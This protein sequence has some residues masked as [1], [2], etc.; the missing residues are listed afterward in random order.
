MDKW[1]IYSRDGS[2]KHQSITQYNSD[3]RIV[4]QD[5]LEYTGNWMGECFLTVSIKSPYPID[6]QIG[7]YI[8]YR[9]E[10]FTLQYDPTVLKS[11]RRGAYSEGFTY[12]S[13][14][15]QS[16]SNELTQIRFHDW[17]LS[18]NLLNYTS[19]PSFS[20]YCKDVDDLADRLQAN[21]D[22]WCRANNRAKEDY[23]LFYTL[24]S[25]PSGT[26]DSSQT[27][28]TYE[29]T[30]QRA[31]DILSS[32]GIENS[33]SE[34]S[35]FLV[36]VKSQWESTY[37]TGTSYAD[38]RTDERFDRTISASSQTVWDALAFVKSQF[39]LNFIIRGRN[40]YIGTAGIPTFHLFQYGRG[41]GL[42][43]VNRTADTEQA[44]ITKL[45]A[46]GSNQNLPTRYYATL[47]TAPA[48]TVSA[49]DGKTDS[50]S[51]T[52]TTLYAIFTV[53]LAFSPN[54]FTRLYL[55]A[56]SNQAPTDQYLV[57]IRIDSY[58]VSALAS[59]I[60]SS[61]L[62]QLRVGWS[63]DS[64]SPNANNQDN[65]IGFINA[66][67]GGAVVYFSTGA[68]KSAFPSS[69]LRNTL[70][71]VLPDNMAVTSLML[72]GFPDYAL[73]DLCRCEYDETS[74]V[75]K[76]YIRTSPK[77]DFPT[78]PFYT[79][80]GKHLLS[81]S[82][83][84]YD[85]FLLSPNA[86]TLGVLEGDISCTED[87]DDNGLEAVYPTLEEVTD[88][89]AG[90]GTSGKRLDAVVIADFIDDNGV[91]P[92]DKTSNIPNFNIYLP[93]LGFDLRQA[94]EDAGGSE[95]QIS[96]KNGFC[97]GR[98]FKVTSVR[99]VDSVN[100]TVAF[101]AVLA[102]EDYFSTKF[103]RTGF[104]DDQP[105]QVS[106]LPIKAAWRLN[107][108]RVSDS[109]LDLYFPY[110]YSSSVGNVPSSMTHAYQILSG[111]NY[112]I[113]GIE[114]SDVNYVWAAAV[115]LLSKAIHY[116]CQ[117]DYTRYVYNPKID[118][119]FMARQHQDALADTTGATK[120]LHDTLKEGDLLLFSDSDL[121]LQGSV[122]IDQLH[123]RESNNNGIP[124]YDITLR[125]ET[126]VGS[127]QRLQNKVDSISTD[128]R[129]GNI[130]NSWTTPQLD[131][132][133]STLGNRYFLSKTANDTAAGI[134][135]FLNDI[136]VAGSA[137]TGGLFNTGDFT[138]RG[139]IENG[140][141]ITNSGSITTKDL[142]VTG[143]AHFFSLT[144][145]EI[146]ATG[147]AFLATPAGGF[148]ADI[149][150]PYDA[151]K[152]L[153]SSDSSDTPA[154]W[155]IYWRA[156]QN[157]KSTLNMWVK[158]DMAVCQ[159]FDV[160]EG[161]TQ[162]TANRRW[163]RLVTATSNEN[164][165]T[166]FDYTFD[167]EF[168][169]A[170]AANGAI[171]ET[172]PETG[173]EHLYHWIE[174]SNTS[175][176]DGIIQYYDPSDTP[177]AG[178]E[179]V[180]LGYWGIEKEGALTNDDD[181]RAR[182]SAIYYS[183]YSSM[184]SGLQAPFFAFYEGINH[185]A[186]LKD[187]RKSY[188][189]ANKMVVYGEVHMQSG[190]D[191]YRAAVDRG[192]YD[193][194]AT[195]NQYDR[196]SYDGSLWL[197]VSETSSSGVTPGTDETKWLRQVSKGDTGAT[198]A[199]GADGKSVYSQYSVDGDNWVSE[200][201]EGVVYKYIRTSQDGKTWSDPIKIQ[202]EDGQN[203]VSVNIT[204][205]M[206]VLGMN[207][208]P[209]EDT[210]IVIYP[211][212]W[213]G[214]EDRISDCLVWYD[215]GDA[216]DFTLLSNGS[217]RVEKLTTKNRAALRSAPN[218]V[219]KITIQYYGGTPP[220]TTTTT[221]EPTA[222]AAKA[223]IL[224]ETSDAS[225]VVEDTTTTTS[226]TTTT[227]PELL[228]TFVVYWNYSMAT[229]GL[230]IDDTYTKL[231]T[232]YV[233]SDGTVNKAEM[234]T[235]VEEDGTTVV[236]MKAN[237]IRLEGY[238]TINGGTKIDTEG[239]LI[240]KNATL[241]G[242]LRSS[243]LSDWQNDGAAG[244]YRHYVITGGAGGDDKYDSALN[245][246]VSQSS[247]GDI[248]NIIH[249]PV[250]PEYIGARVII[251]ATPFVSNTGQ[252][253]S[254]TATDGDLLGDGWTYI[255]AG[256]VFVKHAY[257]DPNSTSGPED[258]KGPYDTPTEAWGESVAWFL[259]GA[260]V[261]PSIGG[262]YYPRR[263]A[264]K[265]GAVELLGVSSMTKGTISKNTYAISASK[266]HLKDTTTATGKDSMGGQEVELTQWVVVNAQCNDIE[267]LFDA[268]G[269][270]DG[271]TTTQ[272]EEKN[273][274]AMDE[275]EAAATTTTTTSSTS[276]STSTSTTTE[277]P[278]ASAKANTAT[279]DEDD[280]SSLEQAVSDYENDNI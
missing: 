239:N 114:I 194:E 85:P 62:T 179:V 228:M 155:R 163:W 244:S 237:Q 118:D 200:L 258:G 72:P 234:G 223:N 161:T 21:T 3:G 206:G 132:L 269:S 172:D 241:N 4:Y 79:E 119:I 109:S 160:A 143:L 142:T 276:T 131:A 166:G 64:T 222:V 113:T 141:D 75:T 90:I 195:Y 129:T 170:N 93:E 184:D 266:T 252:I 70:P 219:V 130:G 63:S 232:Q 103:N 24:K 30:S 207:Y 120:S 229:S 235:L 256:K 245:L 128:I 185:F 89:Q 280:T 182:R 20:F 92:T 220:T 68:N 2:P 102:N 7:D 150:E 54:Y 81:F 1:I 44:V 247:A 37:G 249:L 151:D 34:Y 275:A 50:P 159:T 211:H 215:A 45:H 147:G 69:N 108:N 205:G 218:G 15:F 176:S 177:Q 231:W 248:T 193:S 125:N 136:I 178:D 158:G 127:L 107:C 101:K 60:E 134:I 32:C 240:T 76:F 214:N 250:D 84:K 277:E 122:F 253:G 196:V 16:L 29:R 274:T 167:I 254:S 51:S 212:L 12:D 98:T 6:F 153:L 217:A 157:G 268:Y 181:R 58:L 140:G 106:N 190:K 116:L 273:A 272:A 31:A 226:T 110:S 197:Y 100:D 191:Y 257:I 261:N 77:A 243:V 87:N 36:S 124:T 46:Y 91:W 43:E 251:I 53:N 154:Y 18:D 8:V 188:K 199:T 264:M 224:S 78:T 80:S 246:M 270:V 260:R 22:R 10:R 71:N 262:T 49:I 168:T 25:N 227:E 95:I 88:I 27:P 242:Y 11:A 61:G 42:Y 164:R 152:N 112:V 40:V 201:E 33:S 144:I 115:K 59:R 9:G 66:L 52:S 55:S 97:G 121:Q 67:V 238:T 236:Q 135:T 208:N 255:D 39:G 210:P 162:N 35:S 47:H 148:S 83:N 99:E 175:N 145:D 133:I 233:K 56:S 17:V 82:T 123:I 225:T 156:E 183:A 94:A 28:T 105:Y 13:L 86:S 204:P 271:N 259:G 48:A 38:Y 165:S 14:K 192:A 146:R 278:T 203:G 41:L 137:S 96:L 169:D 173:E 23:W 138:N 171:T 198:G 202:G 265:G 5:T 230:D 187:F 216:L 19:L 57:S 104:T 186:D 221:D 111:D 174:V 263:I 73:S 65:V 26:S 267:Y 126:T 139:N 213:V 149:V 74:D 279:T 180:Q 209:S 117:N 189:D